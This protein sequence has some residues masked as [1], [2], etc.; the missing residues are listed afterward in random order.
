MKGLIGQEGKTGIS[1]STPRQRLKIHGAKTEQNVRRSS[2]GTTDLNTPL[3]GSDGATEDEE[4]TALR[5]QT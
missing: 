2:P 4:E 3:T 1:V 5:N